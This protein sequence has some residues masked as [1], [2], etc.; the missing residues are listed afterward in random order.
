MLRDGRCPIKPA[1]PD[2]EQAG[3]SKCVN[4]EKMGRACRRAIAP[5]PV[6]FLRP[7]VSEWMQPL[8]FAGIIEYSKAFKA[9]PE[10]RRYQHYQPTG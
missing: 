7:R 6:I 3:M 1:L 2:Q 4:L 9:L 5:R 10:S 8:V